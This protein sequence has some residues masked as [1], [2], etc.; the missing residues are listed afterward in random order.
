MRVGIISE[1]SLAAEELSRTILL[2]SSHEIHWIADSAATAVSFCAVRTPDVVLM[3]PPFVAI[4]GVA[5]TRQIMLDS[6][7]PILI[8]TE[9]LGGNATFVLDAMGVGAL[10]AIDLPPVGAP[11]PWGGTKALLA[12]M[13]A[14]SKL[15]ERSV[16]GHGKSKAVPAGRTDLL[17]AIGASAGGPA[18]LATVLRALPASFTAPI[19]IVQ[20]VDQEFVP[21]MA[22]WLSDQSGRSVTVAAEGDRPSKN[23]VLVAGAT[24]HLTLKA[25]T[26]LG[27]SAEPRDSAYCPSVDVF[28]QSVAR[29]WS[30]AVIGVLLTGMGRDGAAGLKAL[31]EKGHYTIAQDEATSAVYG[32]PKAAA[33][34]DAAVDVLPLDRIAVKLLEAVGFAAV[35]QEKA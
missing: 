6:P 29:M 34:L 11:S 27:Y 32:M 31:R 4:D 1:R 7:C 22:S 20:H 30:G 16:G 5:V 17:V 28:F 35:R 33:A 18:A 19:V 10:G 3:A 13:D 8:V 26:R 24:G 23:H 14:I 15:T 9:S 12:K 2:R 25:A 21:G